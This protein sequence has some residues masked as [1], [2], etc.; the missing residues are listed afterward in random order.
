MKILF[1]CHRL[2]FPPI[3]GG[4]IRPFNMIRHLSK[5]HSLVVVSLAEGEKELQ[6]GL[7]IKDYCS[8]LITEIL[9]PSTRWLQAYRALFSTTPSS[10][11]YFYSSRL[12]HRVQ[13]TLQKK[14]FDAFIV[15]CAFSA[16]YVLGFQAGIRILD[17]GDL[18]SAKWSTYSKNRRFPISLGYAL[19][20]KKLRRY[21]RELTKHFS[22]CTVTTSGEME[23]YQ[24]LNTPV[25]CTLIPNGVDSAFFS[26][27]GHHPGRR[28]VIVFLGR[29]DYYPNVDGVLHFIERIFP[30][31]QKELPGVEFRIIGSNPRREIRQLARRPGITV[32][33]HVPEVKPFL[34]DATVSIAPLRIAR[35]TQNKILESMALGIPVVSSEQA[36]KGV[37]AVSGEHFLVASEPDEFAHKVIGVIQ[38]VE[39]Q[40]KLSEAGRR[41][42]EKTHS[43]PLSMSILDNLLDCRCED[44]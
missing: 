44:S 38:N 18:D 10:V 27:N 19:E 23:E 13:D 22:H 29:M 6:E 2:P 26:L 33:G 43:W 21:E 24:K 8:G 25:P 17:F 32:T 31:I 36:A 16:Q 11:A 5:R 20:A 42:V 40:R 3:R 14:K 12:H 39:L 7:G 15:H 28:P 1:V 9:P 30:I 41:Q 34:V 37:Q 4:K 35:G